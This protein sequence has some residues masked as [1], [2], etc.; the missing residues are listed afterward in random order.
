MSCPVPAHEAP[1]APVDATEIN[2]DLQPTS[3]PDVL[4]LDDLSL[5]AISLAE[6]AGYRA[7]AIAALTQIA[8]QARAYARLREQHTDLLR[9]FRALRRIPVAA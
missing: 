8:S 5:A 9:Q 3:G 1:N 4:T 2:W 6:A 7:L